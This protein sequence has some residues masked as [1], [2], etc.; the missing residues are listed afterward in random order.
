MQ[1]FA[2]FALSG[3]V[4]WVVGQGAIGRRVTVRQTWAATKGRIGALVGANLLL[5]LAAV[6]GVA[7]V[8][9]GPLAWF[10]TASRRATPGSTLAPGLLLLGGAVVAVVAVVLPRRGA[11][12]PAERSRAVSAFQPD[13][14]TLQVSTSITMALSATRVPLPL[15]SS[16]ARS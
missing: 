8:V 12:S 3:F 13:T 15:H 1:V 10:V 11:P 2:G 16:F 5:A 9:G 6:L 4:A 7:V 14:R